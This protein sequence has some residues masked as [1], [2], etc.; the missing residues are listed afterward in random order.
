[1]AAQI[2]PRPKYRG[3]EVLPRTVQND[4]SDRETV[5]YLSLDVASDLE[6][7]PFFLVERRFNRRKCTRKF[8]RHFVLDYQDVLILPGPGLPSQ[9]LRTA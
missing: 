3:L 4:A 6:T 5:T 9:V 7:V 8:S 1:M 2:A